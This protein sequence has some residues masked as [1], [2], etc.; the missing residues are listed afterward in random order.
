MTKNPFWGLKCTEC[1]QVYNAEYF[2]DPLYTYGSCYET[3]M[4]KRLFTCGK[5]SK[6]GLDEMK[7]LRSEKKGLIGSTKIA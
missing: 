5:C 2:D 3:L 7:A 1:N 4:G 6:I